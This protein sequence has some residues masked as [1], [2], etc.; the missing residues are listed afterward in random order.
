MVEEQL[1]LWA[2]KAQDNQKESEQTI[3]NLL[4]LVFENTESSGVRDEKFSREISELKSNRLRTVAGLDSLP[5]MRRSINESA[6]ALTSCVARMADE[7]RE[8]VRK[9]TSE[10]GWST[11]RGCAGF[12][13]PGA[14]R[15][16]DRVV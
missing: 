3:R 2:D 5:V 10:I 8:S 4:T 9:L 1:T 16:A 13:A 11:R 12:R 14:C 15:F 7:G 6:T